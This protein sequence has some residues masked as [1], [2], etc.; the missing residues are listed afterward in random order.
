MH[1]VALT[2]SVT[3]LGRC[4]D[5]VRTQL[6]YLTADANHSQAP[7]AP[8][9]AH[10]AISTFSRKPLIAI[11]ARFSSELACC[12]QFLHQCVCVFDQ[13]PCTYSTDR[14]KTACSQLKC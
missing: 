8:S 4:M 1:F 11:P 9:P 6:F 2:S 3:Q 14:A 13:K 12:E 10:V 5:Q 7:P